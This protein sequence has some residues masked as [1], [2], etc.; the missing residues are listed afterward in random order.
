MLI[1]GAIRSTLWT[2]I[3]FMQ[4]LVHAE[5]LSLRDRMAPAVLNSD[6]RGFDELLR[7]AEREYRGKNYPAAEEASRKAVE[8]QRLNRKARYLLGLSLAAQRKL[9]SEALENLRL[10]AGDYP[11]AYLEISRIYMDQGQMGQAMEELKKY[12]DSGQ[13]RAK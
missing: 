3:V 11:D 8:K 9:A 12:L 13:L 7:D 10:A 1:R 5:R 6:S 2:V 4:P